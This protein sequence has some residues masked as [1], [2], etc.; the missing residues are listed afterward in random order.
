MSTRLLSDAAMTEAL[1]AALA[2]VL[3]G[4]G[5]VIALSGDLGAGKTTLVRGL[6]HALGHEGPVR[7]PT[8]TLVEPYEFASGTV[9]HLDLYRLAG[10]DELAPLGVREAEGAGTLM[11]VEW[12]ERAAGALPPLD[13]ALR[14]AHHEQGRTV[15]GAAF[16]PLGERCMQVVDSIGVAI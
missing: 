15:S 1:G 8:Y 13:L 5:G 12:P 6:I 11:L 4:Q 2:T 7:S 9:L 3:A 16:S 14:L 10:A